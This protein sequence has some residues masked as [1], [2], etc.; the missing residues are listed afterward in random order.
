MKRVPVRSAILSA[1]FAGA[2]GLQFSDSSGIPAPQL[3]AGQLSAGQLPLVGADLATTKDS[4]SVHTS[5]SLQTVDS[6]RP[7]WRVPVDV[8]WHAGSFFTAN[9]KTGTISRIQEQ[10]QQ[11][12]QEWQVSTH[13]SG[14][15]VAASQLIALD[16]AKH[17]AL[18]LDFDQAR[19]VLSV[20]EQIPVPQDPVSLAVS[21]KQQVAIASRWSHQI[22]LL[23]P[24]SASTNPNAQHWQKTWTFDLDFAPHTMLFVPN[25]QLIVCDAFG[26]RTAVIDSSTGTI[27]RSPEI[28][29]HNIRGLSLSRD[30]QQL[31]MTH[32]NLNDETFTS[33]ERVFWGVVMQNGLETRQLDQFL[34]SDEAATQD[35]HAGNR[36]ASYGGSYGSG[37]YGRGSNY[38]ANQSPNETTSLSSATLTSVHT[39]PLGTPSVGSGDPSEIIVTES[40]TTLLLLSGFNQVAYRTASHL[41]FSRLKV[42]RRPEAIC[43][44]DSQTRACVVNRFDESISVIS[45]E[46]DEPQL[47][48]TIALGPVRELTDAERGEQLFFDASLSLDGW[49]SCHSCHT[50]GHTNGMLADTLGDEGQGAPKKVLSLLGTRDTGPWAWTGGKSSLEDQIKTSLIISMQTTL[51]SEELPIRELGAY[52]RTLEAPPST[53][54]A[55]SVTA[56]ATDPEHANQISNGRREFEA[57]GCV[58][59]H[60]GAEFTSDGIYEVG[61]SDNMGNTQFNPPSLRGVSQ[62]TR[63]FHDGSAESLEAV[64]NSNHHRSEPPLTPDQVQTLKKYLESI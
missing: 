11:V 37:S 21:E 20:R 45:L 59:C 49:Y 3:H 47:L 22:T 33:Y 27:R 60:S 28:H 48:Q 6:T 8:C 2:C 38:T 14:L 1:L 39:Y 25:D 34:A 63:Y 54:A 29:G 32:Q 40:D 9:S 24:P 13:L 51:R 23:S 16:N 50:D 41:P 10:S 58:N 44:N 5:A 4:E 31:H 42:G 35:H 53:T 26:G 19:D 17:V 30:G 15:S 36:S 43:L 7:A 46:G 64:L 12:S 18:I 55:R 57:Q 52:L 61:L 62:R 56:T